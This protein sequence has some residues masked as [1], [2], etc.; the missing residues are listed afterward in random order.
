M[1]E[2]YCEQKENNKLFIFC[3]YI[4]IVQQL[5]EAPTQHTKGHIIDGAWSYGLDTLSHSYCLLFKANNLN[6]KIQKDIK[7]EKRQKIIKRK[8]KNI[9]SK[10]KTHNF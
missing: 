10:I 6:L 1:T 7:N 2:K 3:L 8:F 5:I 4:D 9:E